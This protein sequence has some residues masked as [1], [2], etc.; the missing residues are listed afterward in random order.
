MGYA[1]MDTR[2]YGYLERA[3]TNR[4]RKAL[5][6]LS[7]DE[8]EW[9]NT[10]RK[11][12][13]D[14]NV[15]VME[16]I[17][18]RQLLR[19]M[20]EPKLFYITQNLN[21]IMF[22]VIKQ[23]DFAVALKH[24]IA[25]TEPLPYEIPL[26]KEFLTKV[27]TRISYLRNSV[28]PENLRLTPIQEYLEIVGAKDFSED[29]YSRF[30]SGIGV[31]DANTDRNDELEQYM[32]DILLT[33]HEK[34]LDDCYR[35]R[36]NSYIEQE[37]KRIQQKK[38]EAKQEKLEKDIALSK[39]G[40]DAFQRMFHK[41]IR[42][43][44]GS[45]KIHMGFWS[46]EQKIS[47]YGRD[48]Y[49]VLCCYVF[50]GRCIYRYVGEDNNLVTTF[51]KAKAFKDGFEASDVMAELEKQHPEKLFDAVKLDYQEERVAI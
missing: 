45:E 36:L 4:E 15:L 10:I 35:E 14:L 12:T 22:S 30:G 13:K 34:G 49:F 31:F 37:E 19:K 11:R 39:D 32:M 43:L 38:I 9:I 3:K 20:K 16:L 28:I 17:T 2:I 41:G 23:R 7:S 42:T 25:T 21:R 18:I 1:K 27:N 51:F 24:T 48:A 46:I 5:R 29:I 6:A 33:V 40:M 26:V 8:L 50:Q 44:K 47:E